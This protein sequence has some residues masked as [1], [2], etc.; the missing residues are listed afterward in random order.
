MT[1]LLPPPAFMFITRLATARAKA[2]KENI[3]KGSEHELLLPLATSPS[4]RN[5]NDYYNEFI[6]HLFSCCCCYC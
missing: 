5:N 4:D 2:R 1:H 6:T 3:A